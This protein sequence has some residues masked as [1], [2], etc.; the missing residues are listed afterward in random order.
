MKTICFNPNC[1]QQVNLRNYCTR[2]TQPLSE[3][4]AVAGA[5]SLMSALQEF[6]GG[7]LAS[8]KNAQTHRTAIFA[9][10]TKCTVRDI[11]NLLRG[12][13]G[14]FEC[15]KVEAYVVLTMLDEIVSNQKSYG[16]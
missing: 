14:T 6:R 5:R 3:P 2:C 12:L 7:K 11:L 9:A 16:G 15:T 8:S 10:L 4:V 13:E 1:A